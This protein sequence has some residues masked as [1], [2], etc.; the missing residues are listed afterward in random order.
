MYRANSGRPGMTFT[1]SLPGAS[2]MPSHPK[3]LI[4]RA[5]AST[6]AP[7]R[8]PVATV[9]PIIHHAPPNLCRLD[10]R[11]VLMG[12]AMGGA[13]MVPTGAGI[14]PGVV[15]GTLVGAGQAVYDKKECEAKEK[16]KA[17]YDSY[18]SV[19]KR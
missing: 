19:R 13:A 5:P 18:M 17:R 10:G 11:T 9:A 16:A 12:G 14:L 6:I 8:I 7:V 1:Y 15:G 2:P 3:P 4:F